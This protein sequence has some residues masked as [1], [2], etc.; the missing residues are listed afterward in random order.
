MR[1]RS[2][3]IKECYKLVDKNKVY[4]L[5]EAISILKRVPQP[6]FD[7][8]VEVSF[9]LGIDPKKTDQVV[10]GSVLLP[11]G[12]GKEK[13]VVVLCE[14]ERMA[15]EARKAG[16]DFVGADDLIKKIEEG[17]MEFDAIV[18]PPEMMRRIARLGKVLGPRGLMPS[19]KTGTVT[20]EIGK[21]VEE[22]KKG[23]VEFKND[24]DGGIH[25]AVGRISFPQE[26]IEENVLHLIEAI[27]KKKPAGLKGHYIQSVAISTTMGPGLK[28]EVK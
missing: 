24:K 15:E 20:T 1:K 14:D 13:T 23:R 21:A 27:K 5:K 25:L 2:K 7:Q 26:K 12:V 28:I 11:H 3:R 8:S 22:V 10:R 6:K 18:C 16:A 17:W 9:K 4:E 19:P